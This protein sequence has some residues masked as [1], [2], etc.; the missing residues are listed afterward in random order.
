MIG[1]L[2]QS[3]PAYFLTQPPDPLCSSSVTF[4]F[5]FAAPELRPARF[6]PGGLHI[7]HASFFSL[8]LSFP[9]FSPSLHL[10]FF[11]AWHSSIA[12]MMPLRSSR[13]AMRAFQYQRYVA[14][15]RRPFTSSCAAASNSPHRFSPQKRVQSTAT[16]TTA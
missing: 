3:V 14:S 9:V 12:K 7:I 16:A 1:A 5:S 8:L 15:G 10:V 4:F 13:S 11:S 6:F 2:H